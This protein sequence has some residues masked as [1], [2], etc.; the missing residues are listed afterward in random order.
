MPGEANRG[1]LTRRSLLAAAGLAAL[2][3][4]ASFQDFSWTDT[5]RGR[6]L[7]LRVRWPEGP[8][9][10]PLVLFSHGLGGSR[11]GGEAWGQA[12]REAG[13]VVLHLQHPGSDT[14][15]WVQGLTALRGA[16]NPAQLLNRVADVHFVLDA[17]Q[18][19][20]AAGDGDWR[21]VRLD[22]IGVS[23][24]S[25]GAQT[26]AALAGRRYPVDAPGLVDARPRAFIAFSPSVGPGPLTPAQ[27]YGGVQRPFMVLTG[28]L[29]GDPFGSYATG[30][31]RWQVYDALPAGAKAGLWL[32]GA[33]HMSFGGLTRT[34]REAGPPGARDARA[35]A[36]EPAHR[37][38][39]AQVTSLWWRTWLMDD[40]D[41]R[42]ALRAPPG[43]GPA[44][45]WRL[46]LG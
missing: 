43:L 16:A 20:H 29:D 15:V 32:D 9:P 40:A 13:C 25:F 38:L 46:S 44:D 23:G 35:V 11:D 5:A 1:A 8:G 10:W 17:V 39:I 45:R 24:H 21:R 18:R 41:A 22:A 33:D 27:Q 6:T 36:A 3:A 28:S 34:L 30:E 37:A 12:W 42:A 4:R 26:V 19:R 7:P 31:P 14:A 2:P